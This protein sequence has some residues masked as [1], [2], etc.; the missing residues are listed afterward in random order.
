METR[1]SRVQAISDDPNKQTNKVFTNKARQLKT[2]NDSTRKQVLM[3]Y[4]Q[5]K[6]VGF[7]TRNDKKEKQL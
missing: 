4:K 2:N 1:G 3:S 5:R 7:K 6:K